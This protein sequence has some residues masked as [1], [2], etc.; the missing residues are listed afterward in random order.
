MHFVWHGAVDKTKSPN[1]DFLE[2]DQNKI[3]IN[4]FYKMVRIQPV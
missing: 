2:E 1:I 3:I 4:I